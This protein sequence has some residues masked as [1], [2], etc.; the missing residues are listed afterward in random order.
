MGLRLPAAVMQRLLLQNPPVTAPKDSRINMTVFSSQHQS[1]THGV[2]LTDSVMF[3]GMSVCAI[4]GRVVCVRVCVHAYVCVWGVRV[5]REPSA[6]TWVTVY[7]QRAFVQHDPHGKH[8]LCTK[9]S[10][11]DPTWSQ[12]QQA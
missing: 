9:L 4:S 7:V 8:A 12:T 10:P 5:K 6:S 1:D 11:I 2:R 3:K